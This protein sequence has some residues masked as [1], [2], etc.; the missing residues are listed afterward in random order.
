[1]TRYVPPTECIFCERPLP[2]WTFWRKVVSL[3]LAPPPFCLVDRET[4]WQ[5][6][7]NRLEGR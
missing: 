5:L 4:C 1:M 2:P 6:A 3:G 7:I